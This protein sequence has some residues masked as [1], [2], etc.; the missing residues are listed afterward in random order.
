MKKNDINDLI[1]KYN[2]I[3]NY[4]YD[5][6]KSK[7]INNRIKIE[8]IC[9]EHGSFWQ[10]PYSH[11]RGHG[12]PYCSSNKK[13]NNSEFIEKAKL[14]HGD[15]YI[16]E[17]I[18]YKNNST[19]VDIICKKHGSFKQTPGKH[20]IG[21]G[22]P[23]CGGSSV[24]TTDEFK[25]R[26]I[27]VHGDLYNY[28][29]VDYRNAR[30]KVDIICKNHGKF[31]QKPNNHLSG[32]GCLICR[33]SKGEIKIFNHLNENKIEFIQEY[34]LSD[35][36]QY[37][38]FYIPSINIAIEYDGVQHFEPIKFFGGKLALEKTQNRDR[39]KNIYCEENNIKLF[40]ISY[41]EIDK[42][43]IILN[44]IFKDYNV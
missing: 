6:S 32:Y 23:E 42:I 35:I 27:L 24:L 33:S 5:Y 34:Y 3:H 13:M 20:L 38:D 31:S 29:K 40:R 12:C 10:S 22:C 2:E 21:R 11:S 7:Y 30:T 28:D 37:L 26:A 8:I 14:I 39:I 44:K 4:K 19:P 43:D 16:Y 36:N 25:R 18:N 1:F 9:K 41:K 17:S 15:L